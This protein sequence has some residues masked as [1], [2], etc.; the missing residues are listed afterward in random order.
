MSRRRRKRHDAVQIV[1]KLREAEALLSNGG[2]LG[3]VC[4]KLEVSEATYHRWKNQ[5]GGLSKSEARRLRVLEKENARLKR[6]VADQALDLSLMK[7]V[8]EGKW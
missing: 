1:G 3:Q 2:S 8:V 5:Y 6:L 7:E 4:Q